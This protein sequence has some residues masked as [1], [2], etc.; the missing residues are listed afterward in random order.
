MDA[1]PGDVAGST[2]TVRYGTGKR[3]VTH[4]D[5]FDGFPAF[6]HDGS[7]LLWTSQRDGSGSSQVWVGDFVMDLEAP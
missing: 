6:N 5:G 3:R 4:A 1:D 7:K 2:G